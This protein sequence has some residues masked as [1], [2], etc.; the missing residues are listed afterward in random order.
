MDYGSG[1]STAYETGVLV[2][3]T[4]F[5][6]FIYLAAMVLYHAMYWRVFTK[7]GRPGWASLI[8]LYNSYCL[9][10]MAGK[11]GWWLFLMWIPLINL[12]ASILWVV[13]FS[14][15]FGQDI[16]FAVGLFLLPFVFVFILAFS[17]MRYVGP[18]ERPAGT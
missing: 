3:G 4:L 5:V 13:D 18:P 12:V 9:M 6:F 16:G 10:K 11:P 17:D 8:P 2:G 15:S 7:A 1:T 14:R